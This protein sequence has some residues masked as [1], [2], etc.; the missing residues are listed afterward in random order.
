MV[1]DGS[2]LQNIAGKTRR[3]VHA[4]WS[5]VLPGLCLSVSISSHSFSY[6]L[7]LLRVLVSTPALPLYTLKCPHATAECRAVSQHL[8]WRNF[9]LI[10]LMLRVL[11]GHIRES[12][13]VLHQCGWHGWAGPKPAER[14][15]ELPLWLPH[16]LLQTSLSPETR[17]PLLWEMPCLWPVD[18]GKWLSSVLLWTKG[19]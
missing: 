6:H 10:H 2:L 9:F 16:T 11:A 13:P 7:Y 17:M 3:S 1:S 19:G 5:W 14:S 15:P 18:Q 4:W 8:G 12:L